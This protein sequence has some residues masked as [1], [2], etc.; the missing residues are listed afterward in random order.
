MSSATTPPAAV[1]PRRWRMRLA[2]A[3]TV[4]F[5]LVLIAANHA[6]WLAT[7]IL[8]T[9]SFVEAL[10][11]LPADPDVSRALGEAVADSVIASNEVGQAIADTL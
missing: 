4:L 11:P 5:G 6:G 9:E 2:A 3:L 7:T 8:D 1:V 10:A